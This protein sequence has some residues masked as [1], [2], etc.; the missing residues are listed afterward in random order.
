MKRLIRT[1]TAI[2]LLLAATA[3]FALDKKDAIGK[4]TLDEKK[5]AAAA[6]GN[7]AGL[8]KE[9]NVKADGTFEAMYGTQ[10]TWK[11]SGG[12]LLVTYANGGFRKDE[13]A[14]MADGFLKFP[15]PA[16]SGKFCYL[17]RQ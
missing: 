5:S 7:T 1:L 10:G 17:R 6:D 14:T 8:M 3:G 2:A 15:S 16:M 11:I 9:V 12:K 13:P 4:W